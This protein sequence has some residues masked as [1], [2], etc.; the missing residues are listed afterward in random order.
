MENLPPELA[1]QHS[2]VGKFVQAF[3]ELDKVNAIPED[4]A[5]TIMISFV[6]EGDNAVDGMNLA[7]SCLESMHLSGKEGVPVLRVPP[8]WASLYGPP[9]NQSFY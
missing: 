9:V 2:M 6:S 1:P 3:R 7:A 8:S 5:V 4:T